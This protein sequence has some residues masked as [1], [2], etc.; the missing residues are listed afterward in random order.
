MKCGLAVRARRMSAV[1]GSFSVTPSQPPAP[2][3]TRHSACTAVTEQDGF[4]GLVRAAWRYQ[5]AV[6]PQAALKLLVL[7]YP[8]PVELRLASWQGST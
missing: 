3:P 7:L 4:G 2:T 6:E 8:R 5:G 1:I